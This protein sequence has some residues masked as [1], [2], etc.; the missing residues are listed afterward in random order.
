VRI[1][2]IQ[3]HAQAILGTEQALLIQ[4]YYYPKRGLQHERERER[5]REIESKAY[6]LMENV[7][8]NCT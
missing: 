4:H 5:E 1:K 8:Q 6:Q 3:I 7:K 2:L